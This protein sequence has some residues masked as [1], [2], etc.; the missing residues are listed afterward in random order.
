MSYRV[1]HIIDCY[2]PETMNWLE[3]LWYCS[4]DRCEHHI[5]ADYFIKP[6][7]GP[8]KFLTAGQ[9]KSYPLSI[10]DKIRLKLSIYKKIKEL[11]IR[12]EQNVFDR[13]HV[14][15]GHMAVRYQ[16]FLLESK[17]PLSIS[18]YGFDLEYL[19][20]KKPETKSIYLRLANHGAE[21][22]VEGE[23]SKKTLMSYG[24]AEE[25]IKVVHM[26]FG[27]GKISHPKF[28]QQPICLL[29]AASF[30]EKKNQLGF[31][32]ALK[33]RH[34]SKFRIKLI[35]EAADSYY[36]K[37]V[38]AM[39]KVKKQHQIQILD[40]MPLDC[41][42][43]ELHNCHFSV[44]LSKKTIDLDSEA[45]CPVFIKD[46]LCLARPVLSTFHCDIPELIV[47]DF[48]GLLCP[49]NDSSAVSDNLD[50]LLLMSHNDYLQFCRNAIESVKIN[51]ENN[52]TANDLYAAY[53]IQ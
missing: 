40:K 19:V 32:D 12:L 8:I 37:E 10:T 44:Q 14:H 16:G 41:Y 48:N 46:S 53:G 51:L 7:S 39:A 22:I 38:K 13:I 30:T 3:A 43:K 31:L 24:I 52:Q 47:H 1:L 21:F 25:N 9:I 23:Y 50:K 35:G 26:L 4:L 2:L 20:R 34:S 11:S 49:E 6:A 28:Y 33:D 29:Q 36:F 27:R 18:I 5:H 15:F 45:G 42:V 17:I